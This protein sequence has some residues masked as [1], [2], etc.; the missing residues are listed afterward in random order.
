MEGVITA[1]VEENLLSDQRYCKAFVR[2]RE[3]KLQGP[4]KIR[5]ALGAKGVGGQLISE[6]LSQPDEEWIELAAE[7]LQRKGFSDTGIQQRA[8]YYRRLMNRGFSHSQAMGAIDTV[9]G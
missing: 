9:I 5:A 1:L 8:R 6:A 3:R 2:S 4:V 7:W